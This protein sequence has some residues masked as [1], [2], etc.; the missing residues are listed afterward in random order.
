MK[1]RKTGN[2]WFWILFKYENIP[3]FCFFCGIL[4]HSDK[5]CSKLFDTPTEEISKPYGPWMRAPLRRQTK[6]IG[7][8]WLR[9]FITDDRNPVAGETWSTNE[10]MYHDPQNQEENMHEGE[11][12][13]IVTTQGVNAGVLNETA[14]RKDNIQTNSTKAGIT[15]VESKKK[16][17]WRW[18]GSDK[19]A[20]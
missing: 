7:S 14:I 8:K 1:I 2:D 12:Y 18:A 20:D 16:E 13:G 3:T 19:G 17:D 11:N 6:M 5:F 9:E 10:G 4:G 15:V